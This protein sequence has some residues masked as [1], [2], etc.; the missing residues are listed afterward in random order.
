MTKNLCN[1]TLP[2]NPDLISTCSTVKDSYALVL[3]L[4]ISPGKSNSASICRAP[5]GAPIEYA[6]SILHISNHVPQY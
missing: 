6:H 3:M 5:I 2:V 4:Y 1:L